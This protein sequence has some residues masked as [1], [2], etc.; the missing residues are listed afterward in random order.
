MSLMTASLPRSILA[1]PFSMCVSHSFFGSIN[2]NLKSD[3]LVPLPKAVKATICETLPCVNAFLICMAS[4]T[5]LPELSVPGVSTTLSSAA[6]PQAFA[7]AN[8]LVTVLNP[9]ALMHKEPVTALKNL[10]LPDPWRPMRTIFLFRK[11]GPNSRVSSP[12]PVVLSR[13]CCMS[14]GMYKSPQLGSKSS[15]LMNFVVKRSGL[16]VCPSIRNL[17]ANSHGERPRANSCPSTSTH[18]E[19]QGT[20]APPECPFMAKPW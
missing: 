3:A 9:G 8:S 2:R 10:V 19:K 5:T 7:Q 12:S 20:N 11:T 1:K 6:G 17:S 18:P 13:I 16:N 4:S 14:S 15:V